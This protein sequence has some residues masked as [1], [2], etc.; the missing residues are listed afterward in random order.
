MKSATGFLLQEFVYQS[1]YQYVEAYLRKGDS[2]AGFLQSEPSAEWRNYLQY[3]DIYAAKLEEMAKASGV[4][5]AVVF[6]PNRAQAALISMGHWPPGLSPY[7]LGAELR[8]IVVSHGGTYIDILPEFRNIPNPEQY[9]Y[10]VDGHP[11]ARG[12]ALLARLL[13][14]ELANGVPALKPAVQL[15]NALEQVR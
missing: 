8:S 9:Y 13:A 12:H 3:L 6:V 10:P 2:E 7:K 15:P 4:P 1:Q 5:L 11:N 14:S